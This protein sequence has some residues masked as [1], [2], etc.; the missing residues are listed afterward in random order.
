MCCARLRVPTRFAGG[1]ALRRRAC[2]GN[3]T[4]VRGR[5]RRRRSQDGLGRGSAA[6]RPGD[7]GSVGGID[8]GVTGRLGPGARARV[9]YLWRSDP[10]PGDGG[11][12]WDQRGDTGVAAE[13]QQKRTRGAGHGDQR[14][15]T[16][17]WMEM[18][19]GGLQL[20]PASAA[21]ITLQKIAGCVLNQSAGRAITLSPR[22]LACSL[23]PQI[24]TPPFHA[25]L[26]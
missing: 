22:A 7:C 24:Y 18:A 20:R 26:C 14:W 12:G 9:A 6:A 3:T 1:R 15:R 5:R 19:G 11:L 2:V 8:A 10:G 16:K 21:R 4:L 23:L 17:T 13:K 25:R